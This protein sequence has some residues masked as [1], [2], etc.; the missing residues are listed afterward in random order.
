[1]IEQ[2][3]QKPKGA[4]FAKVNDRSNL[5][6][7]TKRNKYFRE[8]QEPMDYEVLKDK[9]R[10]MWKEDELERHKTHEQICLLSYKSHSFNFREL[11]K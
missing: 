2:R 4:D 7:K 5:K 8:I 10:A 1:V 6:K 3:E 9:F 11:N